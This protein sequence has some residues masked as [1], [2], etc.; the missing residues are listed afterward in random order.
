MRSA[1][2]LLMQEVSLR[3]HKS[4][5]IIG[6]GAPYAPILLITLPN[7]KCL[8]VEIFQTNQQLARLLTQIE[9]YR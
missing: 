2:L 9:V 7:W 3:V 4:K 5:L 1:Q 6:N 8:S